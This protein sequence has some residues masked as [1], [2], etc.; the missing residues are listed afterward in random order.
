[1]E[2]YLQ[3]FFDYQDQLFWKE[4]IDDKNERIKM[5]LKSDECK[6]FINN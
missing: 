3:A 1:M 2:E 5:W 6:T 4:D